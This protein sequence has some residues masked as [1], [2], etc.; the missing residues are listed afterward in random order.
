MST[1]IIDGAEIR[2]DTTADL[3]NAV[4]RLARESGHFAEVDP[5]LDYADAWFEECELSNYEFD[6]LFCVNF[7]GSEGIYIDA[8]IRG[9]F[10]ESGKSGI[11]RIGTIKTL[12]DDLE[13]M[14]LMGK[15]CGTL[16]YFAR[17]YVNQEI[18][19]YT[20]E[21]ELRA[22]LDR[23]KQKIHKLQ[24]MTEIQVDIQRFEKQFNAAYQFL[25]ENNDNVIG[26]RAAL[27]AAEDFLSK[28]GSFVGE[29]ARYRGDYITS[30]REMVAFMFAL[31][32]MM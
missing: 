5:I 31:C 17:Q 20:S 6:A 15:A 3:F 13:G 23:K 25:Y 22:D 29:F 12:R 2:R 30:D 7:G 16:T 9:V 26:Y 14:E 10:D 21:R 19:R 1:I 28:H 27:E 4:L 32:K 24:Q 18:D 11:K 8:Y